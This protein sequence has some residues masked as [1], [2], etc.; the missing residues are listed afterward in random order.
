MRRM[1]VVKKND[2]K[3]YLRVG[4]EQQKCDILVHRRQSE[5]K[6][7]EFDWQ[8]LAC[9][10]LLLSA[11][12]IVKIIFGFASESENGAA[13]PWEKMPFQT[14]QYNRQIVRR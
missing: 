1:E 3:D 7:G 10:I 6:S 11:C 13:N 14:Q 9:L 2:V 8:K 5:D 4:H 12:L